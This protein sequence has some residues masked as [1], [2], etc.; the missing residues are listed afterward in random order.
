M[1]EEYCKSFIQWNSL[2]NLQKLDIDIYYFGI[3]VWQNRQENGRCFKTKITLFTLQNR[4]GTIQHQRLHT[5]ERYSNYVKFACWYLWATWVVVGVAV[6]IGATGSMLMV[7]EPGV[8]MLSM[9]FNSI[10]VNVIWICLFS[11]MISGGVENSHIIFLKV[12]L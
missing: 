11:L 4:S 5:S 2:K 3:F 12:T 1:N 6:S 7:S 8:W 10:A 9:D